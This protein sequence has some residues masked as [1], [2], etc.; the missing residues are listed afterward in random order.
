MAYDSDDIFSSPALAA[1]QSEMI[2]HQHALAR[3]R[4]DALLGNVSL[5]DID[6]VVPSDIMDGSSALGSSLLEIMDGKDPSKTGSPNIVL[7]KV[8]FMGAI[9]R[10]TSPLATAAAY[11]SRVAG[12]IGVLSPPVLSFRA[13]MP[14]DGSRWVCLDCIARRRPFYRLTPGSSSAEYGRA[15]LSHAIAPQSPGAPLS[16]A[17]SRDRGPARRAPASSYRPR[18]SSPPP[19]ASWSQVAGLCDGPRVIA[20]GLRQVPLRT[21]PPSPPQPLRGLRRCSRSLSPTLGQERRQSWLRRPA[22][23]AGSRLVA[24]LSLDPRF[25]WG[26]SAARLIGTAAETARAEARRRLGVGPDMVWRRSAPPATGRSPSFRSHVNA[27]AQPRQPQ[28]RQPKP[29]SVGLRGQPPGPLS[30]LVSTPCLDRRAPLHLVRSSSVRGGRGGGGQGGG[31]CCI[32]G[33]NV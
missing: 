2:S 30:A 13:K 17:T 28:P 33:G 3:L 20:A 21:S 25:P 16:A 31:G 14:H 24:G 23:T 15:F 9:N 8:S 22:A 10:N 29:P 11:S 26:A 18:S 5:H 1:V 12:T 7:Q 6:A 27:A 32:C 4:I 19:R